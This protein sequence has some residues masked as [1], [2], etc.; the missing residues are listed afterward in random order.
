M[1]HRAFVPFCV[2]ALIATLLS[3]G[4]AS[5]GPGGGGGGGGHGGGGG[6]SHSG[7]GAFHGGG[8]GFHGGG[9]QGFGRPSG[10]HYRGGYGWRGYH[11][12]GYGWGW[13]GIGLGIYLP[14]LPWD[15]ET[16]WWNGVPYYYAN[17]MYYAWDG[18]VGEYEAV[19][20]PSGPGEVPPQGSAA[21]PRVS[22]ELF[23]Y[24][25]GGQSE[26]QQKQD[27]DECRAW[28]TKQTGFDPS[29]TAPPDQQDI[30]DAQRGYLRAEAACLEGRNYSVR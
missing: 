26:A 18:A 29:Q 2:I 27:R 23:A 5:A 6:G 16:Y 28:A 15:Y 19:D 22:P 9:G 13:G 12:R 10:G 7:G 1:S 3:I 14:Y 8:G 21:S 25:K 11:G 30:G 20:P 24:P 4:V 17:D